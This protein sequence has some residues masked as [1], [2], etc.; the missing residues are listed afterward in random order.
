MVIIRI[1]PGWVSTSEDLEVAGFRLVGLVIKGSEVRPV[2]S[3]R[4]GIRTGGFGSVDS[5][6]RERDDRSQR[7]GRLL[8]SHPERST[9]IQFTAREVQDERDMRNAINKIEGWEAFIV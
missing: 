8:A 4:V 3:G 6:G 2:P 1:P 7:T 9:T 5:R